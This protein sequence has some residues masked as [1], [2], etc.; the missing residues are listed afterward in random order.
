MTGTEPAHEPHRPSWTCVVCPAGTPW[1]CPPARTQLAEAY[2]DDP[3]GLST[4]LAAM[5]PYAADEAAISDPAE[6]HERFVA[7][8]WTP[9]DPDSRPQKADQW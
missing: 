4:D 6:L 1:P 5:L 8:T 2:V 9:A 3:V 7:W